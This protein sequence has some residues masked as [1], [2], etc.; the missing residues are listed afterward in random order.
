VDRTARS[1]LTGSS[2]GIMAWRMMSKS[3]SGTR[4]RPNL[5]AA[6]Q[7]ALFRMNDRAPMSG[8][9]GASRQAAN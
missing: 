9:M 3:A 2:T 7:L 6:P 5:N 1:R 8:R 4:S